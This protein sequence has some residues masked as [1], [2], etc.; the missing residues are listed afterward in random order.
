L[1]GCTFKINVSLVDCHF[2]VVPCLGTLTTW[3]SS[4]ADSEVFIGQSYRSSEFYAGI[5]GVSDKAVGYLL[6]GLEGSTT[7]GDS[8]LFNFLVFDDLFFVFISHWFD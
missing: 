8:G 5:F 7:E 3:S 6:D 1:S 2:P 4:A